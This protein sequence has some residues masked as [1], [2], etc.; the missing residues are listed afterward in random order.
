MRRSRKETAHTDERGSWLPPK[1]VTYGKKPVDEEKTR[2]EGISWYLTAYLPEE[3]P[4][5]PCPRRVS[6][7]VCMRASSFSENGFTFR[8]DGAIGSSGRKF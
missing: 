1:T 7:M 6:T 2:Q 4:F 3:T 8:R 5:L